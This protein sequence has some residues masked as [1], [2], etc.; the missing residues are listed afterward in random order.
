MEKNTKTLIK[1]FLYYG[2]TCTACV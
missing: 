1:T 2:R